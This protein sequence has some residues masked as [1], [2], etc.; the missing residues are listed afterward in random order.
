MQYATTRTGTFVKWREQHSKRMCA[1]CKCILVRPSIATKFSISKSTSTRHFSLQQGL[2]EDALEA[3]LGQGDV[4]RN[5]Q[6]NTEAGEWCAMHERMQQNSAF[7]KATAVFRAQKC[8]LTVAN[9]LLS[10]SPQ[11]GEGEPGSGIAPTGDGGA[12]AVKGTPAGARAGYEG[13]ARVVTHLEDAKSIRKAS[14][15]NF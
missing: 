6:G 11:I 5:E 8:R 10:P 15:L 12:T 14:E 3:C 4:P 2:E 9:N 7:E 13:P 1:M